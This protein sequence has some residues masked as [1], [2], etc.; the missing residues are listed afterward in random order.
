MQC[1]PLSCHFISLR[2]K[3]PVLKHS[4]SMFL[5]QCQRSSFAPV[6]KHRQNYTFVY[7]NFQF[8]YYV[9]LYGISYILFM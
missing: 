1:S 2:T 9:L 3:H 5:P 7:S 6:Q 4:Q 8:T